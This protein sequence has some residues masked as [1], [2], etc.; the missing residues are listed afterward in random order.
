MKEVN[1]EN[2]EEEKQLYLRE[3]ILNKGYD[4]NEFMDF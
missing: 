2:A 1:G 4:A 3:H